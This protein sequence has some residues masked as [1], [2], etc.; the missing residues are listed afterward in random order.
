VIG[1]LKRLLK[2]MIKNANVLLTNIQRFP[3]MEAISAV[4]KLSMKTFADNAGLF[5]KSH[6][7]FSA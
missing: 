2:N 4:I 1:G 6:T 7:V 3:L 5:C